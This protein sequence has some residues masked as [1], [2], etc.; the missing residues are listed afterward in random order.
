[1]TTIRRALISGFGDASNVKIVTETIDA[2]GK[3]EVQVDVIYSGF[4]G[5]DINMR[6][7]VYPQQK[8]A[9]LYPG[10]CFVGRVAVNGRKSNRF[11][12][13]DLVGA[14][15]VYDSEADKINVEEKYLVAVPPG[16]DT[17]LA[18]AAVL[19]WNTAYGL[20]HRATTIVG[21]GKRIFI[22]GLSGAVGYATMTLCLLEGAEVYGTASLRNH[23]AL[24]G[25]G[26]TPFVYTDK[27]WM[28]EMR[29]RGGAHVVY[30]AL[31]FESYDESWEILVR[32]EPS[33]LVGFG[34][35][36][37]AVQAGSAKPR[38]QLPGTLKL[39]AK[40]GCLWTKRSAGFYYI[41]RTRDTYVPDLQAVL[42]L[43]AEGKFEV[44]IK[45]I[46]DLDNIREPHEQWTKVTGMGSCLIRVDQTA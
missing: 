14:V 26:V 37:N 31:G 28:G 45:K 38:S 12:P 40:N 43:L 16:V 44:P 35:N 15:T 27:A 1:M 18:L 39:L 19:D 34:G 9:P 42:Q 2:P 21:R 20:V 25:L 23:E 46:W 41:D 32:D 4:S 36:L 24:R 5:A 33:R 3:N 7:G 22:H 17:R 29:A 6:L 13:G 30:D 8:T 10:Y 11:R